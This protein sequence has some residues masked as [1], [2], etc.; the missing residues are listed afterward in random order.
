MLDFSYQKLMRST[1]SNDTWSPRRRRAS[2]LENWWL[3]YLMVP[4]RESEKRNE[5][6]SGQAGL[7]ND[8]LQC[9]AFK[10]GAVHW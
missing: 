8:R 7:V 1:S 2:D 3:L 6:F 10:I 5:F 9:P 4:L